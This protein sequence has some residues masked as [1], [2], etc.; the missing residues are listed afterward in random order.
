MFRKSAPSRDRLARTIHNSKPWGSGPLPV[1]LI[2]R[3]QR[4]AALRG[5]AL[6]ARAAHSTEFVADFHGNAVLR[7]AA[8]SLLLPTEGK[9][10]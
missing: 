2:E 4:E 1:S 3:A 6:T 8:Y 10:S 5:V 9:S 7:P